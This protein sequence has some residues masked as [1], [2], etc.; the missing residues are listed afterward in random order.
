MKLSKAE[1][2]RKDREFQRAVV[3]RDRKCL[4]C[5]KVGR[6]NDAGEI[7]DL[8]AHHWDKKRRHGKWEID[9]ERY[10]P[11]KGV[12]VCTING[13]HQWAENNPRESREYF[14]KIMEERKKCHH[15]I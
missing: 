2:K 7:E 12:S 4:R 14:R 5:G 11:D 13:C 9:G 15:F 6:R 8:S 1:I 3:E 10:D